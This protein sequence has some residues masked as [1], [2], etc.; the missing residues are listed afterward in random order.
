[1]NDKTNFPIVIISG[2]NASGKSSLGIDLAQKYNGEIISADSRQIFNGF[3]LCCGKVSQEERTKIPHHMIDICNIGDSFS[4][5][6]YQKEVYK[7]IFQI[8]QR[9]KLPF[10]VGGTGLYIDAV[11]KGYDFTDEI[12]DPKF[13][14]SLEAKSLKELQAMLSEPATIH[15]KKNY[16]DYNNKRRLIRI[17]EKEVNGSPLLVKNKPLFDTLQIGVTWPQHLLDKRIDARLETRIKQGMI[18][19]VRE[20]LRNGGNPE[21]LYSLGLE[22]KYITWYVEGKYPTIEVFFNEMSKAIKRFAKKQIKWFKRNEA[23]HWLDMTG[24]YLEESYNLIDA[25]LC[26]IK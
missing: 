20:Y 22:Y 18:D 12:I 16:S 13:R 11:V 19:E 10:I 21:H 1:M 5:A 7:L 2:T 15:L 9:G 23:I 3:D 4:V 14:K 8:V 6:D 17:I 26:N 25:F 24:N